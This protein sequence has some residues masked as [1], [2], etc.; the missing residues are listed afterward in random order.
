MCFHFIYLC[1]FFLNGGLVYKLYIL[2]ITIIIHLLLYII[3][4]KAVQNVQL[5]LQTEV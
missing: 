4:F 1:I 3:V 5:S 2:I